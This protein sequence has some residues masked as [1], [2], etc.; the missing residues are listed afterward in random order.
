MS[1]ETGGARQSAVFSV[2]VAGTGGLAPRHA[3]GGGVRGAE[4]IDKS[5]A[6]AVVHRAVSL[7]DCEPDL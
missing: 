3:A 7:W 1:C 5:P 2:R 4:T 6:T